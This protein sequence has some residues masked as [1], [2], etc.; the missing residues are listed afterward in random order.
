MKIIDLRIKNYKCL[1]DFELLDAPD[2]VVLAGPNGTGKS[3]VLEAILFFKERIGAYYSWEL[4]GTIVNATAPFAEISIKFKVFPEEIEYLKKLHNRELEGDTLEGWIKIGKNGNLIESKIPNELSILLRTY[5]NEDFPNVGIFDFYNPNRFM[6]RK[7]LRSIT[8]GAFDD[9]EEKRR[10]VTF[11]PGIKFNLTKDYLA[12]CALG[13]LQTLQRKVRKEQVKVG[14]EDLSDS[15]EP[16]KSI[17]NNLLAPKKLKEV[18]ISSSPIT[19][20]V[21]TPQGEVDI[22]DLSSGEKE[23][24]FGYTELLKLHPQ[25]SI[26]LYDEPDLHLNQE[27]ERKIIPILRSI[28]ANNQFWI[29]T[30]SFGIMDS[31]EY[32][33][34]FRLE[35]YSGSNQV[36][37][38]FGDEEKYSTFRSVAGDVGIVTLG[39]KIVF[40]EGTEWTDKHILETFFEEYK[41][42]V[43]FVS[44][45]SVRDVTGISQK[46]LDL[47]H[48]S[49]RF[50][51][52]YAI[53]DRDFM[54][55]SE[56]KRV[57]EG[58]NQR[59]YVWERYHIE[60]YLLNFE[61]IYQV[62]KR[63]LTPC[64]CS[65]SKDVKE[66]IVEILRQESD[67][68]LSMMIKYYVNKELRGSYFDIGYSRIEDHAIEQ[69][70]KLKNKLSQIFKRDTMLQII[71]KKRKEFEEAIE[72]DE[73]TRMLPGRHILGL[74]IGKYG[75]GLA[76]KP[77]KNQLVHE[78][79]DRDEITKELK[80]AV[81]QL[82]KI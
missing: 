66:K 43:T 50:N 31:V 49:S 3:S 59:L 22:D 61:A 67:R 60:N 4:P 39:Q 65:D 15:L 29:A 56:R 10:R 40:L 24:L 38:V 71:G 11:L 46:I 18:D 48:T 1:V 25:N 52:Y 82:L 51:F 78:I 44:S 62:L 42:K 35:N 5:R 74:F 14:P 21:E 8:V 75:K 30:H 13:D 17:F 58:G 73:W 28:G 27:V 63:N 2:V 72:S 53:R 76:Y 37:R 9:R 32:R 55:K 80:A 26:I 69:A 47:L 64:P 41:G 57:M 77:F 34:L 79:K 70:E 81:S 68:F 36:T 20:V 12:Q 45:G 16:I 23:I 6:G 54:E 33:E 7:E 19:F